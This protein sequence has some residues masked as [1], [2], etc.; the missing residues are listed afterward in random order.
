MSADDLLQF[1]PMA[2]HCSVTTLISSISDSDIITS[3]DGECSVAE[4]ASARP[5]WARARLGG[6]CVE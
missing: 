3:A 6:G 1:L 2:M 5:A 4:S